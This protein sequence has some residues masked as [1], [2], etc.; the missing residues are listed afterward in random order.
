[1]LGLEPMR[2]I[3]CQ[4]PMFDSY[5]SLIVSNAPDGAAFDHDAMQSRGLSVLRSHFD[6]SRLGG[7]AHWSDC[8]TAPKPFSS[9]R[10]TRRVSSHPIPQAAQSAVRPVQL[11]KVRL[12][13]LGNALRTS[14]EDLS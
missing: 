11:G 2:L 4:S 14:R 1:M 12:T 13:T 10:A 9:H 3:R 7:A 5:L 8:P 6:T